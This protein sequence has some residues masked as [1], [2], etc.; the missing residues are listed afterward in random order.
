M[1]SMELGWRNRPPGSDIKN[2]Q[3]DSKRSFPRQIQ[4][5]DI[6]K[7]QTGISIIV[8]LEIFRVK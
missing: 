6:Q 4:Q 8:L 1:V 2:I 7:R 3:D 5:K